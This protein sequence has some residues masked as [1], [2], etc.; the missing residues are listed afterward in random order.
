MAY[1][2]LTRQE[3]RYMDINECVEKAVPACVYRQGER[4]DHPIVSYGLAFFFNYATINHTGI[5]SCRDL[6]MRTID[7]LYS[8]FYVD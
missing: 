1:G 5:Q 4:V 2:N 8:V 3:W 6:K 7:I